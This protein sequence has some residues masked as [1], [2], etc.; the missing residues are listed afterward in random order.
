MISPSSIAPTLLDDDR[1]TFTRGV[2]TDISKH[3][4]DVRLP[5]DDNQTFKLD[6]NTVIRDEDGNRKNHDDLQVG[7]VV[8]ITSG[9]DDTADLLVDGG[10]NGFRQ[11]GT[12]DIGGRLDERGRWDWRARPRS[13]SL[14]P[15][16]HG[17]RPPLQQPE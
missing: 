17:R 15:A 6:D 16:R 5:N 10:L 14:Q 7:D 4:V 2:L 1:D 8:I 3:K 12:F 11:G 13:A 9:D